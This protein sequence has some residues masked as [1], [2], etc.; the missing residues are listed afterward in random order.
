[1]FSGF[2]LSYTLITILRIRVLRI[3]T[4]G[5]S[6]SDLQ[7]KNPDDLNLQIDAVET[8][9]NLI[10]TKFLMWRVKCEDRREHN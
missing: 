9:K 2:A 8:F 10:I 4:S 6:N 7:S 3:F 5:I 1:M